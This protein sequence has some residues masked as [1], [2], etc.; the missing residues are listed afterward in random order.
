METLIGQQ[1]NQSDPDSLALAMSLAKPNVREIYVG[2]LQLRQ[3]AQQMAVFL[4]SL[5]EADKLNTEQRVELAEKLVRCRI[6]IDEADV[7]RR[8]LSAAQPAAV[9]NLIQQIQTIRSLSDSIRISVD[10]ASKVIRDV[11]SFIKKDIQSTQKRISVRDN[12]SVVLNIFH[13]ELKRDITLDF[14]V[15]PDHFIMGYEVKLFQLWSNLIKNAI[16]AMEEEADKRLIIRSEK[17]EAGLAVTVENTGPEIPSDMI[18]QIFRKFFST[19]HHKSGT[20]L[21]IVKNVADE[22]GATVSVTSQ[23]RRTAFTVTF[24]PV[25]GC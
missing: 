5:T 12:I 7:I 16:D 11:R 17:R 25:E 8:I 3:E 14:E 13:Y 22:H 6:T 24:S 19:K 21:G 1:L 4:S 18:G 9:L 15:A 23:D 2:G 20:G 10:R